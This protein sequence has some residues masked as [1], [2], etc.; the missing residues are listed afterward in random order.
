[1][2]LRRAITLAFEIVAVM[3]AQPSWADNTLGAAARV[4]PSTGT[5][6]PAAVRP[7]GP[8]ERTCAPWD[9][10]GIEF[11]AKAGD[12]W[13]VADIWKA[14]SDIG[15]GEIQLGD[16][17]TGTVRICK[18]RVWTGHGSCRVVKQGTVKVSKAAGGLY[19]GSIDAD[20]I[21]GQFE[22]QLANGVGPF[23]G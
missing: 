16:A 7:P 18:N 22:G 19:A 1:M 8:V 5:V 12:S 14:P 9:G 15:P 4:M 21:K 11:A 3:V 10:P 17:K 23:C 6:Q 2:I 13:L 20:G